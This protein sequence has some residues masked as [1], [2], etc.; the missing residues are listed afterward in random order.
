MGIG[1]FSNAEGAFDD[2]R[3]HE[4]PIPGTGPVDAGSSW[5]ASKGESFTI[6]DAVAPAGTYLWTADPATDV[7]ITGQTTLT[8]TV[9]YTGSTTG[10]PTIIELTLDY[11][12]GAD[13]DT[14]KIYIYDDPCSVAIGAGQVLDLGDFSQDCTTSLDDFAAMAEEWLKEFNLTAPIEKP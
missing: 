3:L 11:N 14:T 5:N 4:G 1:F 12:S 6:D 7:T 2:F 10:N 8:P 13:S 9:T